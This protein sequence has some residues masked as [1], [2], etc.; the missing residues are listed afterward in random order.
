MHI[1]VSDWHTFVYLIPVDMHVYND[2]YASLCVYMQV[3]I[4]NVYWVGRLSV[5]QL[6]CILLTF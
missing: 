5:L 3:R 2:I 6:I 4:M 1:C